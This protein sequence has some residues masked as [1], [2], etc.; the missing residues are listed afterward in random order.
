MFLVGILYH[1]RL[2]VSTDNYEFFIFS[3]RITK[4]S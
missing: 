1:K 4:L 3:K 2:G